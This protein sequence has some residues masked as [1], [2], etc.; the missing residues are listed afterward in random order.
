[1]GKVLEGSRTVSY[2]PLQKG[3]VI[4]LYKLPSG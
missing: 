4:H 1:V 3:S 2:Y